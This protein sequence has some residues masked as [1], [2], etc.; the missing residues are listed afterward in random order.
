[1]AADLV[2]G[3]GAELVGVAMAGLLVGAF[4]VPWSITALGLLV[5]DDR[6][7]SS[8][9]PTSG[10]QD[11]PT[12]RQLVVAAGGVGGGGSAGAPHPRRGGSADP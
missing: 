5:A 9:R 12:T 2:A 3:S 4:G 11:D 8:T 1:M 10:T 6:R 7:C